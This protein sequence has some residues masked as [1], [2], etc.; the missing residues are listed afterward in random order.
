[1]FHMT[2]I[3]VVVAKLM[4]CRLP[5]DAQD[6][7]DP[8]VPTGQGDRDELRQARLRRGARNQELL[9][10]VL[11]PR[12]LPAHRPLSTNGSLR[13]EQGNGQVKRHGQ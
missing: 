3:V 12:R 6:V 2:A 5:G 7:N 9:L 11:R 8:T 4:V 10:R 13:P 1:M